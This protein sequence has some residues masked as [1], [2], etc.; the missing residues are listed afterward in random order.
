MGILGG[1]KHLLSSIPP[2]SLILFSSPVAVF[3]LSTSTSAL[4]KLSFLMVVYQLVVA[5][6]LYP[7]PVDKHLGDLQFNALQT[8]R[9]TRV[10]SAA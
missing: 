2:G 6:F 10:F 4:V 3:R 5:E 8:K 9:I 7:A 1:H